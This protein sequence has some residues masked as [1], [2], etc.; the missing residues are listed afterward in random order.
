MPEKK[1]QYIASVFNKSS[2]LLDNPFKRYVVEANDDASNRKLRIQTKSL[3]SSFKDITVVPLEGA[4]IE[5]PQGFWAKQSN[6]GD[7][8][9]ISSSGQKIVCDHVRGVKEFAEALEGTHKKLQPAPPP[10]PIWHLNLTD[11]ELEDFGV[12]FP[13]A[14]GIIWH[15]IYDFDG[16]VPLSANRS[17]YI[18]RFAET[19]WVKEGDV[20]GSYGNQHRTFASVYAPFSGKLLRVNG[21]EDGPQ[22]WNY[23]I[24][25]PGFIPKS[26]I[27]EY[28]KENALAVMQP[29]KGTY[30]RNSLANAYTE[31]SYSLEQLA[32]D[33]KRGDTVRGGT[34][35]EKNIQEF[36]TASK[37][38]M[39]HMPHSE[40]SIISAPNL[41]RYKAFIAPNQ[42]DLGLNL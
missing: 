23:D 36:M 11:N 37:S 19:N 8:T 26:T 34:W 38:F 18:L 14:P 20:I 41:K 15:A 24:H 22:E 12:M 27:N 29:L 30:K 16:T 13:I 7:V 42:S 35:S 10:E 17:S 21:V 9:V 40:N 25:W 39:Q 3:V 2:T 1:L 28:I 33:V 5:R 6:R 32:K 31:F 4:T